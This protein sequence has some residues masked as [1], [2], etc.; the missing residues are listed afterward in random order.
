MVTVIIVRVTG[1]LPGPQCPADGPRRR[2]SCRAKSSQPSG[3]PTSTL[4]G[5]FSAPVACALLDFLPLPSFNKRPL[6]TYHE[7]GSLA[8]TGER[9]VGMMSVLAMVVTVH[10]DEENLR[11]I[12]LGLLHSKARH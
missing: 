11:A 2:P 10:L 3:Q 5:G 7:I 4:P 6:P 9:G 8:D 12:F 1:E